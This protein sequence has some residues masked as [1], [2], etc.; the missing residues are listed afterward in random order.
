MPRQWPLEHLR[1]V[2]QANPSKFASLYQGEPRTRDG[3]LFRAPTYYSELP[4]SYRVGYGVDLAYI[5]SN[6]G[7]CWSNGVWSASAC[8]ANLR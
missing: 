8:P 1:E 5:A 6:L 3:T 7:R 4:S 2:R